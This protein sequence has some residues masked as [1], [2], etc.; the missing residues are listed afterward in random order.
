MA[1]TKNLDP[2]KVQIDEKSCKNILICYVDQLTPN[3]VNPLYLI[4]SKINE[5]IVESIRNEYLT[6]VPVNESKDTLK[7]YEELWNKIRELIRSITKNSD[8]Y[9]KKYMKIQFNSNDNLTLKKRQN[10]IAW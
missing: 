3:R 8:N 7:E 9:D 5:Y 1:N 6:L 4:I 2:S 10:I